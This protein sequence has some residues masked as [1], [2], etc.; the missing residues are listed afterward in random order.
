MKKV[1]KSLAIYLVPIILIAFFVT[2]TQNNTLSTKYF[3]V[4]EMI[5][6]VKKDNVKEIVA[7]GNDIKGVLKDSKGT[8]FRMYMPPEMWEVFYNNYLKESVENNKIVLKTEKDPGKPWYVDIMPTILIIVGLGIIW[9]MFM[10]QTQNSGNSKA[11]NFGKSK[12]KLNQDSKEKVVFADVAGLKEE[13]EE[14]MEIVDFLKNPSKYIDIG[15]RIPKGVLLVGPPGTGKTYLSRAVAG[16]AKV[17]F[18]SISGS[19]FVEMF[20]GVGASR[21][22]DLFEQAKKNAPCIIFIDEIDAVGRK[23]GAG[24]GGG[25]DEREQTLNQLLVEMDGFGKNE[26]VIVMSA[27]NRPDIL[28]KALLRP[29][30]FDRTIYVGLP[31]VR[32]R[33]EI[34]KVHTK[35][36]KLKSD[37]DLENIAKTTTGFSPADL[38]NLCNEAALLAARNNEAEISNEVFKEASIKVVAGP[39]KKSQVVIEKERVLTAYH[40]SGHAIVSGFLEDND[41]VHMITIIPRGRAGGF[42]AYLPQEDAK[43]MTKRQM[44][45]KLISLLGGR[46]AEDVVLDDISTGASNDIERA[47]KIAHAMVTKY[48]MS[49]RLGP[50]MYGGD[51]SEVFLGEELGKNKQY[52]DKIAYEIDSEMRELID[53]AYNKAL[54]ILNENIDLLHALANR[55][56]EK[57]TI[58]QEEFEAIFDKYTKTK[59]HEN[60]PKELVDVRKKDEEIENNIEN[61]EK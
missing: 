5:V 41:K 15:A 54:N 23:R 25:H 52:S 43:F 26:G 61:Q 7:R 22:R 33:L 10:N 57:E 21:V 39:E 16:E 34:L 40:E 31:D 30:R 35:N 28:D 45:H 48:G 2:M 56:L 38:E 37:V 17:P 44:Q 32:E 8:P 1:T 14:L 4:N 42:T 60:E 20:V 13:K 3:T 24:L 59:I 27:T 50:M 47:T 55:L 12:A 19:D 46:A 9:F 6:N 36:K 49:K 18:F 53:E 58:G 11:M 29:G 51:D